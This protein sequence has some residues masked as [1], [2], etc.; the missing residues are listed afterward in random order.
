MSSNQLVTHSGNP[1]LKVIAMV[2]L[3]LYPLLN[4]YAISFPIPL[5]MALILGISVS[6]LVISGFRFEV[7]PLFFYMTI[8]YVFFIWS[9]RRGFS[10]N[11]LLPPGGTLF[12]IFLISLG[13]CTSL[14]DLKVLRRVMGVVV[15]ISIPLFW[16]QFISL[17][18]VGEMYCFVPNLTGHFSYE[19]MTYAQLVANQKSLKSPCSIFL[20]KSYMG[21]Y[22]AAYLCLRLYS[23]DI[24]DKYYS[25]Q[26]IIICLTLLFLR[27][28]SGILAMIVLMAVKM[29]SEYSSSNNKRRFAML[30]LM[31]PVLLLAA[32]S[33]VNTDI[34][35]SVVDRT[36]EFHTEGASGYVRT[37][38]GYVVYGAMPLQER[39]F[40]TTVDNVTA[41][42]D[43]DYISSNRFYANG[44][45]TIL[46]TLGAVGLI[47]YLL[48]YGFVFRRGD[49]LVKMSIITLL[50]FSLIESDYLNPYHLLLT[51]IP[52]AIVYHHN[53]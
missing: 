20:E 9:Y 15:A 38:A 49:I 50:L 53:R 44:I 19:D 23:S 32:Y 10:L 40:G 28:G 43:F 3:A 45:Q 29:I 26:N 51:A 22:L 48:F 21:Y 24:K 4:W 39:I 13:G 41:Y 36:E 33:Y 30:L 35:S 17:H 1:V 52:C 37:V 5:G 2:L 12:F 27:S 34:G 7:F 8:L 31:T 25:P 47:L 6:G 14:F 18:T 46:M 42:S 11:S 16:I